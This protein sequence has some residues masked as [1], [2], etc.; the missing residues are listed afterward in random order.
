M[1]QNRERPLGQNVAKGLL[2][3]PGL[4]SSHLSLAFVTLCASLGACSTLLS[5]AAI[6]KRQSPSKP[7]FNPHDSGHVFSHTHTK[8]VPMLN[9]RP[10]FLFF[11]LGGSADAWWE[12]PTRYTSAKKDS[13]ES[14]TKPRDDANKYGGSQTFCPFLSTLNPP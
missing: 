3:H 2:C 11:G 13:R 5:W 7:I 12:H 4:A 14:S 10:R 6:E 9:G 1:A 8:K